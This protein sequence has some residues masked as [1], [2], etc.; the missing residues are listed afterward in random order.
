MMIAPVAASIAV[1]STI[2][3]RRYG[4]GLVSAGKATT[5]GGAGTDPDDNDL[6]FVVI[7]VLTVVAV[8]GIMAV[9]VKH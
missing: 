8:L 2:N 3:A 9:F 5:V 6:L 7:G 1:S 4:Y